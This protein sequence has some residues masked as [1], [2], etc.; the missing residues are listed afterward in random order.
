M[1]LFGFEIR[2]PE[3]EQEIPTFAQ[4][5]EDDGAVNIASGNVYG[6]YVDL[7]GTFRTEAELVNKYRMMAFNPEIDMAIDEVVNEAIVV[8]EGKDTVSII[9]DDLEEMLDEKYRR[10]I[11]EEFKEVLRL[12]EFRTKAYDIFR[13]W[14]RD[15]R[16]YYHKIVY[17]G[18]EEEGI[19]ELRYL[20]PRKIRKVRENYKKKVAGNQL[21]GQ[22]ITLYKK[23]KEFFLYNELGLSSN[24]R[25]NVTAGAQTANAIK[26]AKD[27]I[28]H[29]TSG[30]LDAANKMTLSYLHKAM[31]VMNQLRAMEDATVIYRI[32]RAPERRVFY[33]DVGSLP[34]PKAEQ[35]LKDMMTRFKNRLVYDA[36]TGEIRDD[37]RFMT[38]LEDF[39]LPRREGGRGTEISTLPGG[40]NLGQMEDVKYF[41][42]KLY[43][44]LNVP[45]SRLDP[46]TVYNVGRATEITRDEVRFAKFIDRLRLKFSELFTDA[47]ETQLILKGILTPEEWKQVKHKIRYRYLRDNY[48]SELKDSEIMMERFNRLRDADDYAGKYFSHM[49]LRKYLLRQTDEE[50]VELDREIDAE[51]QMPQYNPPPPPMPP[52]MTAMGQAQAQAEEYQNM[53]DEWDKEDKLFLDENDESSVNDEIDIALKEELVDLLRKENDKAID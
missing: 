41:Q 5:I 42:G 25:Y 52:E 43:N 20:D 51:T 32:T 29:C 23:S 33:I 46:E 45:V 34:K 10:L 53:F 6:T 31:R 39:W 13:T 4:K 9:L 12:L 16:L 7:D 47:L 24:Q 50:I 8:E 14:Y 17:Q 49:W 19:Q 21:T 40:Q 37:R 44:S 38:M 35:H 48:F 28:L 36:S 30:L 2:R 18:R 26:I 3:D 27:S 15:G 11:H 22:D 1:R